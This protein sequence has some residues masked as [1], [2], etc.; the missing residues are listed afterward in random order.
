MT[1]SFHQWQLVVKLKALP[2]PDDLAVAVASKRGAR[3]EKTRYAR[4]H[5]GFFE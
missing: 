4:R 3:Q 5:A 2:L 1:T